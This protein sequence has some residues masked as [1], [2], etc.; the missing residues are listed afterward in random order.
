MQS[1]NVIERMSMEKYVNIVGTFD[2]CT[3]Q[4]KAHVVAEKHVLNVCN[5]INICTVSFSNK[6]EAK[7]K[8]YVMNDDS[9]NNNIVN[10]IHDRKISQ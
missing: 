7:R 9:Y 5:V 10:R 4:I 6:F 1:N 8:P 3:K 2:N